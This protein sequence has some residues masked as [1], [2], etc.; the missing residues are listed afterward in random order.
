[1]RV[2][3]G[4]AGPHWGSDGAVREGGAWA[5]P[6]AYS[7]FSRGYLDTEGSLVTLS[8]GG[9]SADW[10]GPR[11]P[12]GQCRS[13]PRCPL[14][15]APLVSP[16][17]TEDQCESGSHLPK[18]TGSTSSPPRTPSPSRASSA[19]GLGLEA[20]L[21]PTPL[22]G[23]P[24]PQAAPPVL[25]MATRTANRDLI[26]GQLND[27][28]Y[29]SGLVDEAYAIIYEG[30]PSVRNAVRSARNSLMN[31]F[32]HIAPAATKHASWVAGRPV[33]DDVEALFQTDN[34]GGEVR[35]QIMIYT[36]LAVASVRIDSDGTDAQKD[37][38]G[39][40]SGAQLHSNLRRIWSFGD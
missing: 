1:M 2:R 38:W 7:Q 40:R 6:C 28:A 18:G 26:V 11:H 5:F 19:R 30:C 22:A 21:V 20:V 12:C 14:P 37:S 32:G 29:L 39:G 36:V 4:Y 35:E 15:R 10:S 3:V 33:Y 23:V 25:D 34:T 27:D 16:G 24:Q 17:P 13:Y 31:N 8:Q 9:V